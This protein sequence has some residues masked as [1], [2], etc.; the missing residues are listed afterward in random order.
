MWHHLITILTGAAIG[1]VILAITLNWETVTQWFTQNTTKNSEYG[2]L[3]K[4]ALDGGHYTV[5]A[6]VFNSAGDLTATHKWEKTKL[7]QK[8]VHE[9]GD[10]NMVVFK[11]AA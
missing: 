6:G 7:D 4:E 2:V 11:I 5:V 1:A 10:S 8:L 3:L 9:F